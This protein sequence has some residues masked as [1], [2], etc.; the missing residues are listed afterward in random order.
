MPP[1]AKDAGGPPKRVM[2]GRPSNNVAIGIVGL[3][4]VGKSSLCVCERVEAP[5]T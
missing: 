2:L 3:P 1:K 5:A 4:N